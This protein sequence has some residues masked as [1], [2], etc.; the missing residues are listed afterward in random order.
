M[1]DDEDDEDSDLSVKIKDDEPPKDHEQVW[2]SHDSYRSSNQDKKE[3]SDAE[4]HILSNSAL[5]SEIGSSGDELG[6]NDEYFN[7]NKYKY[8]G[9]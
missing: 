1:I 8:P 3:G 9:V 4:Q 6:V 5:D 2:S 7:F